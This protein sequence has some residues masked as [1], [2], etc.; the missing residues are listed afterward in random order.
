MDGGT[1]A[2]DSAF[3]LGCKGGVLLAIDGDKALALENVRG[4]SFVKSWKTALPSITNESVEYDGI[5]L[6]DSPL[7][8]S[9]AKLGKL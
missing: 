1:G 9:G 7:S 8:K 3:V 4:L 2:P 6:G 5:S